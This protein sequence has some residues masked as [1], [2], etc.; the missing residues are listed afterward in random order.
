ML[1]NLK[2]KLLNVNLF[3]SSEDRTAYVKDTVNV[4]A[5]AGI[6]QHYQTLWEELHNANAEN[7]KDADRIALEV[8]Q[9]SGKINSQ[10]ENL[11]LLSHILST[12]S[13]TSNITRCLDSIN[14]LYKT[15][16]SVEAELVKLESLIDQMGFENLKNRHNYH[17]NQYELRKE[18]SLEKF[19]IK[20]EESHDKKVAEYEA[21]KKAVQQERQKVFQDAFKTDMELYKSM[22][23]IPEI[24]KK[25]QNGALLEEIQI[26]YDQKELD[27]FFNDS[28]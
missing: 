4:N 15:S 16:H 1:S 12:S 2:D 19:Q 6:L 23:T 25:G 17:L 20:L 18:E 13:L 5:G 26:D 11:E 28:S 9:I 24:T 3:S 8:D 10:K 27:Q 21:S 14:D 7:A 22:G